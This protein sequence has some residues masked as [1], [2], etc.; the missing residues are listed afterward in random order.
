M[1]IKYELRMTNTH[2][3]QIVGHDTANQKSYL[4]ALNMDL[5]IK[6]AFFV[7]TRDHKHNCSLFYTK[8]LTKTR[9]KSILNEYCYITDSQEYKQF[10]TEHSSIS[11][12]IKDQNV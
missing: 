11:H 10:I 6:M 12:T 2:I 3:N 4:A 9:H 1:C 8:T 5:N 7:I